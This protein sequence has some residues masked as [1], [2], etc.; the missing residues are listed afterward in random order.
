[1]WRGYRFHFTLRRVAPWAAH[2]LRAGAAQI[3]LAGVVHAV[4]GGQDPEAAAPQAPPGTPDRLPAQES[5]CFPIASLHLQGAEGQR[6]EWR[7][8]LLSQA[9]GHRVLPTP[10]PPQGRCL[11]AQGIQVIINRLQQAL[12]AR[13]EVTSRVLAGPQDLRG[14]TLTLT[15]V[16]GIVE[17]IRWA[18]GSGERATLWNTV[19]TGP[20]DIL[21]L[22]A[23]EQA[24][25]NFRRVPGVEA[26]IQIEPGAQPGGSVLTVSHRQDRWI[27]LAVTADDS[28]N[29]STGKYQGS[30]TLSLDNAWT[31]SDLFYLTLLQDLGGREPGSRGTRGQ[32]L[33]YSL[34]WGPAL[35]GLTYTDHR[36][37]QTVAGAEQD[38]LYWGTSRSS[39]VALSWLLHR[40]PSTRTVASLKAFQR[41]SS[42]H[43]D[44]TEIEVQRRQ[45]A[46]FELGLKHQ[47]RWARGNL[48]LSVQA[49]RGTGGW[50]SLP[51]PE[52]ALGE[53]T[54]RMRLWLVEGS[55]QQG[56]NAGAQPLHYT[57][58]WRAQHNRTPL[59]PQDRIAI[60]GRHSVR[61]FD[62]Q[63]VLSAERGGWIRHEVATPLLPQ[64]QAYLGVDAGQV[65]GPRANELVGRR[66]TGAVLGLRG[67]AS[68]LQGDVFVGGPLRKPAGFR[69]ARTT[70]GF[71]LAM[72]F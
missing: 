58:A 19:P 30:V 55:L 3:L 13:G 52:E 1:M 42:N 24:L 31:L 53:G 21:N 5:P 28:G 45:V 38:Y 26:D 40:D 18:P 46:G 66:L 8:W 16:P 62:G 50:G 11:G 6:R 65:A 36:Y 59:T 17:G 4:Q 15:W 34:P 20:G 14:G 9:D 72:S 47:R 29:R 12:I 2:V 57:V 51:A 10:D 22:R 71:S 68:G 7:E 37:F 25:E 23:L 61:G 63:F 64:L 69:T 35:L 54:S 41:A 32:V 39:E 49:R 67:Q 70:A 44:D 27:R 56:F 43:I 33:H 48:E 60:G